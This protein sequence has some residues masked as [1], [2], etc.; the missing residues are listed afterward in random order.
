[1]SVTVIVRRASAGASV[2]EDH[3]IEL[4][5]PASLAGSDRARATVGQLR[6]ATATRLGVLGNTL[7]FVARGK[8]LADDDV[9]ADVASAGPEPGT[10][11]VFVLTR[12]S[13]SPARPGA[14]APGATAANNA[15]AISRV[16]PGVSPPRETATGGG[17]AAQ[18]ENGGAGTGAPEDGEAQPPAAAGA[19]RVMFNV[20]GNVVDAQEMDLP[21]EELARL[22]DWAMRRH[23]EDQQHAQRHGHAAQGERLV[24][25]AAARA[26]HGGESPF[27]MIVK[28]IFGVWLLSRGGGQS[29]MFVLGVMA[30]LLFLARSGYLPSLSVDSVARVLVKPLPA[31]VEQTEGAAEQQQPAEAAPRP[32]IGIVQELLNFVIPFFWSLFPSWTVAQ[33]DALRPPR[34]VPAAEP[35]NPE[36]AAPPRQEEQH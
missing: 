35:A 3:R 22:R 26:Q 29:R 17:T 5:P 32:R 6:A 27:W 14:A 23:M 16:P 12:S 13:N 7:R 34:A 10:F 4:S 15:A 33:L 24:D 1:M 18:Q 19:P 25:P 36:A 30:L 28:L 21:P 11:L 20:N 31:P 8:V 2:P 9:V